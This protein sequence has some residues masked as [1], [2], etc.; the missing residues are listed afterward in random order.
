MKSAFEW[1]VHGSADGFAWT[2]VGTGKLDSTNLLPLNP[3][4]PASEPDES[5]DCVR[6]VRLCFLSHTSTG[7]VHEL[8]FFDRD[9]NE[10]PPKMTSL[11]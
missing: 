10:H 9:F 11:N 7:L 3:R 4:T 6:T 2:H 8:H 5:D 1:A